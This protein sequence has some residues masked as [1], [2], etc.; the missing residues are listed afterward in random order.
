MLLKHSYCLKN[1]GQNIQKTRIKKTYL[2]LKRHPEVS[3]EPVVDGDEASGD[4]GDESDE[5]DI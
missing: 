5:S 1:S 2:G 4:D 3:F